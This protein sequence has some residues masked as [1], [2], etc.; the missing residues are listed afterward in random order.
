MNQMKGTKLSTTE[1]GEEFKEVR[2]ENCAN[3]TSVFGMPQYKAYSDKFN[4]NQATRLIDQWSVNGIG[5]SER[6]IGVASIYITF[7]VLRF[8]KNVRFLIPTKN[9]PALLCKKDMITMGLDI[10]LKNSTIY[11]GYLRQKF[12]MT[13]YFLVHTWEPEDLQFIVYN[14]QELRTIHISFG[15][16]SVGAT[17]RLF[18]RTSEAT[19]D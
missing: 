9:M 19:L 13:N 10:S 5:G 15:N 4:V 6:G 16:P 2:I 14:E 8:I 1:D 7:E 17:T 18:K 3:R 11:L 12:H